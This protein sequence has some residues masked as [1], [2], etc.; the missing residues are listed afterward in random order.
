MSLNILTM[1]G[2]V[3]QSSEV[4]SP[5]V[6]HK[7]SGIALWPFS[8]SAIT[9]DVT[10]SSDTLNQGTLSFSAQQCKM[11]NLVAQHSSSRV[12]NAVST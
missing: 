11:G 2:I 8:N 7:V 4:H 12:P 5:E 1:S 10:A 3:R 6:H 9:K